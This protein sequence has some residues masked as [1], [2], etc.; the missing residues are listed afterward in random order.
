MA[1]P[2]FEV[3]SDI[4]AFMA[5][6]TKASKDLATEQRKKNRAVSAQVVAWVKSAAAGGT[7]LEQLGAA[8]V[9]PSATS[10]TARVSIRK[11]PGRPAFWGTRKRKGWY[12]APR[13]AGS[14]P[15]FPEW[16]GNSWIAGKRGEGPY[17]IND[18]LADR[19]EEIEALYA[20][21]YEKALGSAFP[22]GFE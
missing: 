10:S 12:A 15:Q 18:V 14:P 17:V 19:V 2:I 22:G 20:E 13:Y 3:S 6:L 16:V 11:G 5:S 9:A 4:G 8:D 21:A 1:E 7:P